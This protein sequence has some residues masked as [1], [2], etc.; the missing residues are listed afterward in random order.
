MSDIKTNE[1]RRKV[2]KTAGVA[3]VAAGAWHKP[4]LNSVV[5]PAH[6]QT[7][8]PV[9][10]ISGA[11]ASSSEPP[12]AMLNKSNND[13]LV[14]NA[15][16]A[17]VPSAQAGV[18]AAD[19]CPLF[20]NFRDDNTHCVSL[21]FPD[22]TDRNGQVTVT[23]QG[24]EIY[25]N[26]QCA[27]QYGGAAYYSYQGSFQI[28]ETNTT[29]MTDGVFEIPLGDATVSGEVDAEFVSASGTMLYTGTITSVG[30]DSFDN[31]SEYC[32]GPS[33]A[34]GVDAYWAAE[35]G[36]P[37]GSCT[38]GGGAAANGGNIVFNSDECLPDEDQS[39]L[40]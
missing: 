4:V 30:L 11:G 25:Y 20:V 40:G 24:P 39:Q 14:D 34:N 9:V 32:A 6:A 26:F 7:S 5:T 13:S 33:T 1:K 21:M 15:I 12:I 16:E 10:M 8:E 35:L 36:E 3:T 22:G 38:V 19:D 18:V 2:L 37:G 27:Y 29:T 28:N 17:L 23:L 31:A